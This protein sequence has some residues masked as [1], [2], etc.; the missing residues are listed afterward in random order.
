[1]GM[2]GE[3]RSATGRK[4]AGT[5]G[6]GGGPRPWDSAGGSVQDESLTGHWEEPR[7]A[8]KYMH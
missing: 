3:L 7:G 2:E 6:R 4:E 1:M 8:S 5:R